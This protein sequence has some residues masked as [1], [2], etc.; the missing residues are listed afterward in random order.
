MEHVT[1]APCIP[2]SGISRNTHTHI[3]THTNGQNGQNGQ[4]R[5]LSYE[6]PR[7]PVEAMSPGCHFRDY[8]PA[9]NKLL[10]PGQVLAGVLTVVP[11]LVV[12]APEVR[13]GPPLV[14]MI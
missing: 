13:P 9:Q 14:R 4:I 7:T 12:W 6:G 3:H 5:K 1:C 11:V 10:K 8:G 2:C